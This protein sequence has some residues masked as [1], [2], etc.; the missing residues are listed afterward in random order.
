MHK[1]TEMHINNFL[2]E[3]EIDLCLLDIINGTYI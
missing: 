3:K 1:H 2:Q